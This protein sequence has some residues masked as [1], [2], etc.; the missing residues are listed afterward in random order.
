MNGAFRFGSAATLAI[1]S[2][3]AFS[4][5]AGTPA[6]S[7]AEATK[8]IEAR[9]A[10]FEDIKKANAPLA[11]MLKREREFD[12]AVVATNAAQI[13]TLLAK[14][15]AAFAVDTHAFKDTKTQARD[16]I[17]VGPA[18]FK[19]KSDDT[20]KAAAALVEAAKTGE[21]SATLKAMGAMGKSCG[22][23]HDNYKDKSAS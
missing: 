11:A 1:A 8:A 14:I 13:Q 5:T 22:A 9:Q 19:A 20:V 21:K 4:Q 7:A 16:N 18:D 10:L 17:W 6:K 2:V 15:P 23:C 3:V 12:A